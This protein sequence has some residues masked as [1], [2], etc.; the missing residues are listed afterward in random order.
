MR[1]VIKIIKIYCFILFCLHRM[2]E[3]VHKV[4]IMLEYQ[5]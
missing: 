5:L 3:D 4:E 1:I 2:F